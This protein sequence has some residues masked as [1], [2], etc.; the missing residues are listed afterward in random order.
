[1][2]EV[3]AEAIIDR[4]NATITTPDPSCITVLA[5]VAC[6]GVGL[7]LYLVVA[8]RGTPRVRRQERLLLADLL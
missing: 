5:E 3:T 6:L 1:M 4:E 2:S 8:S 7:P